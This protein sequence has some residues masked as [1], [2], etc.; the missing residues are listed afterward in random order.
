[1]LLMILLRIGQTQLANS[2]N[3]HLILY[4]VIVGPSILSLQHR[5]ISRYFK[6]KKEINSENLLRD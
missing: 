1:M 5:E 3:R 4:I 2:L 6:S